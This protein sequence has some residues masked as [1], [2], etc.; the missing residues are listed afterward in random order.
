MYLP[1]RQQRALDAIE[2][3]LEAS[4]PRLTA[5]FAMFTRLTRGEPPTDR[6]RLSPARASVR[7]R[8]ALLLLPAA[9]VMV[10][11]TGLLIAASAGGAP[12]CASTISARQSQPAVGCMPRLGQF[13]GLGK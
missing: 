7:W 11:L 9:A 12:A 8:H 3:A 4:A 13:P 10:L 5:M 2:G 6:E 1:A